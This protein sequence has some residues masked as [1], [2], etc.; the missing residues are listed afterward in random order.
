MKQILKW[1]AI[2]AAGLIVII[3]VALLSFCDV[4]HA[5]T[6]RRRRAICTAG[7]WN[8]VIVLGAVVALLS[9][10]LD[11]IAAVRQTTVGSASVGCGVAVLHS[12]VTLF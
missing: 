9:C 11:S 12:V 6:A 8:L 10:V 7:I 1:S 5:V 4:Y 3:I 2:I